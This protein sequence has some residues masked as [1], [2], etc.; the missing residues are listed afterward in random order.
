MDVSLRFS[1]RHK[2]AG[3]LLV[4]A[5]LL[6]T[7]S[8]FSGIIPSD[9]ITDWTPGTVVGVPGGIPKRTAIFVNVRTTINPAYKCQGD[10]TTDDTAALEAALNACPSGQVVYVP[11]GTYKV[12]SMNTDRH[13]GWTLRGDGPGQTILKGYGSSA[14]MLNSGTSDWPGPE[15]GIPITAGAT[16]N[17]STITIADTSGAALGYSGIVDAKVI[18]I[19]ATTDPSYLHKLNGIT[20]PM[21]YTFRVVSHTSTTITFTPKLPID[22]SSYSPKLAFYPTGGLYWLGYHMGVEDLTVDL[23]DKTAGGGFWEL[24]QASCCWMK[25]VEIAN[26]PSRQ[27]LWFSVSQSEIRHCYFHDIKG[28]GPS[29]EGVDL[30]NDS[31]WNLIEDNICINAGFPQI[32]LNDGQRS[33][34][35]NVVAYNYCY[36][37][38]TGGA[39]TTG[40]D[41]GLN[42]GPHNSFNLVEGNICGMVQSDGYY[43]SAS[44]ITIFRNWIR[45]THPTATDGFRGID[46]CHFSNYFNIVGNVIGT[47]DLNGAVYEASGNGYNNRTKVIY[48]LGYPNLGNTY[49]DDTTIGPDTPIDYSSQGSTITTAVAL[50]RNVAA[51]LL[52]HGNYDYVNSKIMWDESISDHN[53]PMSLY[54]PGKPSWWPATLEWPSI[55]PD[56]TGG[57]IPAE[58]R[59]KSM[60][61]TPPEPPSKLRVTP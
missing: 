2:T 48:R 28:G 32:M 45:M 22:L 13:D 1:N 40:S 59:F 34:S 55:G 51:T 7:Q 3:S 23:N 4:L 11:A 54:L 42:H 5:S 19:A 15:A 30:M 10:G 33:C 38:N 61:K 6:W 44:H 24:Y 9:R 29:H 43:G 52:R 16:K 50:D 56:K 47:S 58:I 12:G 35:G 8:A 20:T 39:D 18:R 46:L 36:N 57:T 26:A 14:K 17:S 31:C 21:S 49:Y 37:P 25:N 41:I 27:I 60:G 53:L